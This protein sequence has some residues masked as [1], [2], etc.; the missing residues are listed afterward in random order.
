[1]ANHRDQSRGAGLRFSATVGAFLLACAA[2]S[3]CS[4]SATDSQSAQAS[5]ASGSAAARPSSATAS[6]PRTENK[7]LGVSYVL[8]AGFSESSDGIPEGSLE[9]RLVPE[10]GDSSGPVI[11]ILRIT[12]EAAV[13]GFIA[14]YAGF[15][16]NKTNE[17]NVSA[18]VN[19]SPIEKEG[20]GLGGT[21]K[22]RWSGEGLPGVAA[23]VTLG[24]MTG[25]GPQLHDF[26][27]YL[28]Q[29]ADRWAVLTTEDAA[30]PGKYLGEEAIA[31]AKSLRKLADQ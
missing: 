2:L 3:A 21:K 7:R 5:E 26:F 18:R 9:V 4:P 25:T 16:I 30:M 20:Y 12:D 13:P 31:V 19:V 15:G 17:E 29:G 24:P 6:A 27:A 14:G 22:E 28:G 10:G 1:M 8:P 11:R 23:T